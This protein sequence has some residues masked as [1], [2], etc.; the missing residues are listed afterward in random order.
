MN[1]FQVWWNLTA[2]LVMVRP[3]YVLEEE[4]PFALHTVYVLP[5][6]VTYCVTNNSGKFNYVNLQ[7]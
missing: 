6:P 2:L 7:V 4:L 5:E 3:E 1:L